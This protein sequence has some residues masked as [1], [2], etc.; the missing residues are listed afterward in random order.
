MTQKRID[1]EKLVQ[2]TLRE[3]LPKGRP[4]SVSSWELVMSYGALG[5]RVQTSGPTSSDAFGFVPGAPHEDAER[6]AGAIRNL[7]RAQKIDSESAAR[8]LFGAW[9]PIAEG[10]IGSLMAGIFN[11]QAIVISKGTIGGRPKWDFEHPTPYPVSIQF[12]DNV[13]SLRER[14]LVEGLDADGAL[15]ALKP[16]Q[17]KAVKLRGMYDFAACPRSPLHWSD[18]G[19]LAVGH[20]RAEY[21][22]WHQALCGL[23][24]ALAG[25]LVEFEPIAPAARPRPWIT[26]QAPASKVHS[27]GKTSDVRPLPLAPKRKAAGP[28]LESDI[29]R[30]MR[31]GAAQYRADQRRRKN[32]SKA[33]ATGV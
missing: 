3:E 22:F 25:K 18:P 27:D 6:V 5:A 17:G 31:E 30:Q 4:V 10:F 24:E 12:R 32:E 33:R 9:S 23:V 8:E 29:E 14:K 7:P 2:W 19:L 26:G 1:I 15:V 16:N 21:V 28:P 13:G 20:A 11:A